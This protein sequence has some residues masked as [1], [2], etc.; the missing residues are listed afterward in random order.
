[1]SE[2]VELVPRDGPVDV[3]RI[4][5]YLDELPFAGRDPGSPER[6]IAS[7]SP[8]VST[9]RLARRQARPDGVLLGVLVGVEP[10]RVWMLLDGTA[11]DVLR[12]REI[13]AWVLEHGHF[14]ARRDGQVAD[15]T[16]D[17]LIPEPPLDPAPPPTEPIVFYTGLSPDGP[18][19]RLR[20]YPDG[21]VE[22]EDRAGRT[23]TA[24]LDR[25]ALARWRELV[26]ALDPTEPDP[27]DAA[28]AEPVAALFPVD[29]HTENPLWDAADPPP[30]WEA[31]TQAAVALTRQLDGWRGGPWPAGLVGA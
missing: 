27:E 12:A 30:G 23:V 22:F 11:R 10:D 6:W 3:E 19:T 26:S 29:D 28:L 13:L 21:L 18:A 17:A 2:Y 31:F 15:A 4:R 16:V 25:E 7:E 5:Q 24:R 14:R 20:V 1:V 8:E 9:L